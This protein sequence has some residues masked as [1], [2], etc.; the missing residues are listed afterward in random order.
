MAIVALASSR[1]DLEQQAR[2]RSSW[3]RPPAARA[4]RFARAISRPWARWPA[5]QGRDSPQP[6]ADA[7]GRSGVRAR[8]PLRQHRA[9]LQQR[10]R[11]QNRRS[12]SPTSSSPRPASAPI[13]APR[14]SSTSSAARRGSSPRSPCSS[15]R[16]ARSSCNGGAN[17]KNL[18]AE[19]L[20]ALENGL[21]NLEHHIENVAA[22]RR[23]G[24]R[25]HQPIHHGQRRRARD[26]GRVR[27]QAQ[28]ARG[29]ER[30]VGE[31]R[32][33]RRGARARG[34]RCAR[35]ATRRASAPCTTPSCRSRR[36]STPSSRKVYGGDGADYSAKAD[37]AIEYLE[38]IGL[39]E[40]PVCMAKTQYSVTDDATK[41]GRPTGFRIN[42][43][44]VYPLAGAGFVVAPGGR[45]HDD[46][47]AAE[48]ALGGED[49]HHEGRHHY[50]IVLSARSAGSALSTSERGMC[51]APAYRD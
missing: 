38:S 43:N 35:Q 23:P 29:A 30:G 19:D 12:R 6:R 32:R 45:H 5:A 13:S 16:C 14:S 46:A 51:A 26:G 34:A 47:R 42:V 11:H 22:I 39:G 10:H 17:K 15:R 37:R 24:R 40:T 21:P 3:A 27:A 18:G 1:E 36:R 31:G 28:G 41:L 44:E 20:G 8:G 9:R 50:G 49:E 4:S 48:G 33:R 25:R 2:R 7:R